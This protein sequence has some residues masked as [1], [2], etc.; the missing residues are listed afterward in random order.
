MLF[1]FLQCSSRLFTHSFQLRCL[2]LGTFPGIVAEQRVN[3]CLQEAFPLR[4]ARL[5]TLA[6]WTLHAGS[7]LRAQPILRRA[8]QPF[9]FILYRSLMAQL[10]ADSKMPRSQSAQ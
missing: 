6:L 1:R 7:F 2:A 4:T 9:S 10:L 3:L 8:K 5:L